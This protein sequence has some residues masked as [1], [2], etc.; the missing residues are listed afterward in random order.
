MLSEI[1]CSGAR[2]NWRTTTGGRMATQATTIQFGTDVMPNAIAATK[3]PMTQAAKTSVLV[4]CEDMS[5]V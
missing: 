1:V 2:Q 3:I 5:Q 4:F